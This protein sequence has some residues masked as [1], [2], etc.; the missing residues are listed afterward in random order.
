M[1]KNYIHMNPYNK[2]HYILIEISINININKSNTSN[3][4]FLI[5]KTKNDLCKNKNKNDLFSKS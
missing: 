4:H 2:L 1:H 5:N 3:H